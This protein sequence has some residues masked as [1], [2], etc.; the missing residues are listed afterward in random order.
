MSSYQLSNE[1]ASSKLT[2]IMNEIQAKAN[3]KRRAKYVKQSPGI[4]VSIENSRANNSLHIKI[5]EM[6]NIYYVDSLFYILDSVFRILQNKET[7]RYPVQ[8]INSICNLTK[9]RLKK[10]K[11]NFEKRLEEVETKEDEQ[12][13]EEPT[14]VDEILDLFDGSDSDSDM[15][16]GAADSPEEI[17]ERRETLLNN[18]KYTKSLDNTSLHNYFKTRME[19]YDK[20]LFIN[21][22]GKDYE[23]YSR[24]CQSN[25]KRQPVVLTKKEMEN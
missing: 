20:A 14:E 19:E 25:A 24:I 12:K 4:L 10:P 13:P 6:D 18:E 2:N 17:T 16:G 5:E 9:E 21:K 1:E 15:A 23:A 3:I 11:F 22:K 8:Y 7:T